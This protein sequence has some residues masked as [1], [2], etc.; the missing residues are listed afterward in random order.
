MPNAR[1]AAVVFQCSS[2]LPQSRYLW[3]FP[4]LTQKAPNGRDRGEHSLSKPNAMFV[5]N[6]Q[7]VGFGQNVRKRKSLVVRKAG[8]YG[9][10]AGHGI[11]FELTAIPTV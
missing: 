2:G 9:I 11:A 3:F 6:V 5:E 8:A 4:V 1:P 7:E 10:Q